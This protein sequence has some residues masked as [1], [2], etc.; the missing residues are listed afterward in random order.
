MSQ[1]K[2]PLVDGE[3]YHIYNR[4]N[5]KQKIFLD[6]EDYR[7]FVKCLFVLSTYRHFKFRDNIVDTNIDAFDFKRGDTLV[8]MGAWALMPNHFHI[9][10]TA[11]KTPPHKSDL[12]EDGKRNKIGEFMRKL[13]T[14]YAKYF[15]AK[16]IRTGSLF[17]GVFKS[18]HIKDDVQAK[19]LF[20]YIHLNP[21]KIIDP[22][23]KEKGIK[24]SIG[25]R[26]FLN[27]YE[28]S[29]YLDHI[30]KVRPQNKIMSIN[31]FPKYFKNKE[32]IKEDIFGWFKPVKY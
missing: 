15:N 2:V 17:E 22:E 20:A 31:H 18:V 10:L 11:A 21:V 24:D 23:W 32:T 26:K 7:H 9:Y 4:G 29:S 13:S 8:S 28:W 14:A 19:Y 5:S 6:E 27:S 25:A 30:G 1:R 12:W 16:Y 3:Y